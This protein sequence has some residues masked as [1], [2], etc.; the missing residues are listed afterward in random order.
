LQNQVPFASSVGV[1]RAP[2]YLTV[3]SEDLRPARPAPAVVATMRAD[4]QDV[5][6]RSTVLT[7]PQNI[8]VVMNGERQ[9]AAPCPAIATGDRRKA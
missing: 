7:A 8:Q 1:I 2:Q 5:L 6:A 4:L 3:L 9:R